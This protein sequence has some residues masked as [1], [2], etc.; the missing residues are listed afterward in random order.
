LVSVLEDADVPI[1]SNSDAE[2]QTS[3]GPREI[4]LRQAEDKKEVV[5]SRLGRA[6]EKFSLFKLIDP[7]CC[8]NGC[9]ALSVI[10]IYTTKLESPSRFKNMENINMP[11]IPP[12]PVLKHLK[13][14]MA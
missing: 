14:K 9:N 1:I 6:A 4:S 8:T 11:L 12:S 3:R 10:G 5:S 2:T 13:L 7:P